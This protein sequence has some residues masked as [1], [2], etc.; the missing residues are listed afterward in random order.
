VLAHLLG[1]ASVPIEVHDELVVAKPAGPGVEAL[2]EAFATW[3]DVVELT[4]LGLI[5]YHQLVRSVGPGEAA[6]IAL[7]AQLGADLVVMDDRLGRK[8]AHTKGLRVTGTVGLLVQAQQ[9][10]L[11][12]AVW[13]VVAT[14]REAG[15]WISD[16]LVEKALNMTK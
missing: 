11:I 8:A 5:E 1:R 2:R 10:G 12:K 9:D 16:E 15:L 6:A 13:P 7:A 4:P 3:I 14:M